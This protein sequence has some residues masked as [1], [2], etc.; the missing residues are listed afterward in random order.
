MKI[1]IDYDDTYT[2]DPDMWDQMIQLILLRGHEVWCV[3]ARPESHMGIV[4]STIGSVIGKD[5]CIGTNLKGKRQFV[6]EYYGLKPDVWIDDTPEAI[7][8]DIYNAF[9]N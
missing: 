4:K 8:A 3:S 6:W 1:A 7:G 9:Q 2:K 5:R